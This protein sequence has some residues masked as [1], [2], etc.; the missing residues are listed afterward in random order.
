MSEQK[1]KNF[2]IQWDYKGI[3]TFAIVAILILGWVVFTTKSNLNHIYSHVFNGKIQKIENYRKGT[4]GIWLS[5]SDTEFSIPGFGKY[6]EELS[7]GDSLYKEKDSYEIFIYK[8]KPAGG[9]YLYDTFTVYSQ[10]FG[11]F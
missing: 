5:G 6:Y 2:S 8:R 7:L 11:L 4:L 3:V 9:Y 1:G 10:V